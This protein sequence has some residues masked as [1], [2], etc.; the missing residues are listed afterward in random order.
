VFTGA[1]PAVLVYIHAVVIPM[2]FPAIAPYRRRCCMTPLSF[3][4]IGRGLTAG[5]VTLG[6]IQPAERLEREWHGPVLGRAVPHGAH[7]IAF[8]GVV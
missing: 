5:S 8:S 7:L 6:G 1:I 3:T 2:V 4:R